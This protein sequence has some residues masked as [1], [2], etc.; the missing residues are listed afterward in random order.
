MSD[1]SASAPIRAL[2]PRDARGRFV[3]RAEAKP[4]SARVRRLLPRD[5]RGRFVAYPTTDAPSWYVFSTDR[6]RIPGE[7][8]APVLRVAVPAALPSRQRTTGRTRRPR[9]TRSEL[10]SVLLMLLVIV[11]STWY[12]F[13]LPPPQR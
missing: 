13:H 5:G 2:R 11:V 1:I 7:P 9:F 4:T 8:A 12:G 10:Q 6:Y 3:R